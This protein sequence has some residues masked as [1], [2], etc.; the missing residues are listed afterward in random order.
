MLPYLVMVGFPAVLSLLFLW[1]KVESNRGNKIIVD[2]FFVI[3]LVLLLFRSERVGIDLS[4]YK[5]NFNNYIFLSWKEIFNG[6]FEGEFEAGFVVISKIISYLTDNFRA[7]IIICACISVI[8]IWILYR[9][10]AHI[11]FFAIVM[12]LN[13]APFPMYFSGLRQ[14]MAMALVMPC[15]YFCKNKKIWHFLLMV[16]IAFLF[17]RSAMILLLMYP[18]YHLRLKKAYHIVYIAPI[19]AAIY[20]LKKPIFSFLLNFVGDYADEYEDAIK[21]T[22]AYAVTLL[23][24]I[25]LVYAFLVANSDII[26]YDTMGLRNLMILS[27]ILQ[28]FSGVHTIAMRMNYYFLLLV[29]LAVCKVVKNG[30]KKIK[31]IIH[32]SL[33]CMMAFFFAYYIYFIHTDED[34]LR[35]YPYYSVFD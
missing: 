6:I 31:D 22:G 23:L 18:I 35:I 10:E 16:F 27:V 29:P 1:G 21:D 9:N 2:T 5:M 11:G 14:A 24:A 30:D 25:L 34:I 3:W 32:L 4:V 15:Y 8:P 33:I 7:M 20:V 19:I 28:V 26:D 12:F 13:I 17:H